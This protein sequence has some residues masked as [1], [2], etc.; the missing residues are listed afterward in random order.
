[1][2]ISIIAP[3]LLPRLLVDSIK[4]LQGPFEELESDIDASIEEAISHVSA[5]DIFRRRR[6]QEIT[7]I[8]N[9]RSYGPLMTVL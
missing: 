7:I 1:M 5:H 4:P 3:A 6:C 2:G 8:F 9:S